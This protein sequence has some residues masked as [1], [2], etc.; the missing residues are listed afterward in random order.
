M[1][2][3]EPAREL[4]RTMVELG[5]GVELPTVAVLSGMHEPLGRAIGNALEVREAV[6]TLRGEGP[7]D[8][9]SLCLTLGAEV[10]VTAGAAATRKEARTRLEA[11]LRDGSALEKLRTL[12]EGMSGDTRCIDDPDLLPRAPHV[13]E[14]RAPRAGY[15][16]GI[17]ALA[18]G[19][20]AMR[21]GAG[22]ATKAD[23]IDPAGGIV[24]RVKTGERVEAGQALATV[25]AREPVSVDSLAQLGSAFR[26][27]DVPVSPPDLVLDVIR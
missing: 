14:L 9:V 2:D 7:D 19:Q 26:W 12:V 4:A 18:C 22:R 24:L 3:L 21:L 6:E 23:V 20:T 15:V 11:T 16:A 8:L 25:H 13:E 17:D 5:R 1:K 10:L 27:S